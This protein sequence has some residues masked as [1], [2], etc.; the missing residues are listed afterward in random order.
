M[1]TNDLKQSTTLPP[2]QDAQTKSKLHKTLRSLVREYQELNGTDVIRYDYTPSPLQMYRECISPGRPAVITGAIDHWYARKGWTNEYLRDKIGD[3]MVTVASTPN[4][5]ADAVTLDPVSGKEYFATPYEKKMPFNDFLNIMLG[6]ES[7]YPHYA[8]L[9]NSSLTTE[10]KD[11]VEDVDPDIPWFTEAIGRE[12]DAINF[13][14]GDSRSKT[15]LHKDPYENC[16]AVVRGTKTFV[17]LPPIEYYC[18]HESS[19]P[20]ATYVLDPNGKLKLEPLSGTMKTPCSPV[21]PSD[22]D[23]ERF[24]RF[25]YAKPITV[26]V[27]EGEMLYLPAF[28]MHQVTQDGAEGV[29]A[30]NYWYDLDYQSILYPTV[31]HLR[32][33]VTNVLDDQEDL[34]E[35]DDED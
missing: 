25:Q 10:Y 27:R 8:S 22:P 7:E 2:T 1:F 30:V 16:Y 28:W 5:L 35:S 34:G 24:P 32:R 26:T 6:E 20:C 4:G 9:Q 15:C 17:L 18:V 29:I 11:L 23:L 31:S 13:W 21:D 3:H 14:F 33:L 12:P 19:F